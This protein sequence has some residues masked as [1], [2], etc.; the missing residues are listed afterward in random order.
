MASLSTIWLMNRLLEA[1][2]PSLVYLDTRRTE[3]QDRKLP[4]EAANVWTRADF[5]L[6]PSKYWQLHCG[7]VY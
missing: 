6:Y 5:A 4:L 1:A 3:V 7:L 2:G